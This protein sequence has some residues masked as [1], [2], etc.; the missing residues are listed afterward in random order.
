MRVD[1][2]RLGP[3]PIP[4]ARN[5]MDQHSNTWQTHDGIFSIAIISTLDL[6]ISDTTSSF[7]HYTHSHESHGHYY[8]ATNR[9]KHTQLHRA[10]QFTPIHPLLDP[11]PPPFAHLLPHSLSPQSPA[12]RLAYSLSSHTTCRKTWQLYKGVSL[13]IPELWLLPRLNSQPIA[14]ASAPPLTTSSYTSPK[15]TRDA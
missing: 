8:I 4:M 5:S 1:C 9:T 2:R 3:F 12:H 15:A 10:L 6:P 11:G 14:I 13:L 7:A